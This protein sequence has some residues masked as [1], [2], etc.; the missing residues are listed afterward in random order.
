M[1]AERYVKCPCIPLVKEAEHRRC[2][3]APV[4]V[5]SPPVKFVIAIKQL[6]SSSEHK[7]FQMKKVKKQIRVFGIYPF[8]HMCN[9]RKEKKLNEKKKEIRL[10][11]FVPTSNAADGGFVIFKDKSLEILTVCFYSRERKWVDIS[12]F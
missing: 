10:M 2:S 1:N 5:S 12:I 3:N 6:F 8:L 7:P 9:S 4:C 11:G